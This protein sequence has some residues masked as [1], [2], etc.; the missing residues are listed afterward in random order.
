MRCWRGPTSKS[1]ANRLL[2]LATLHPAPVNISRLPPSSD[3]LTL[4]DCL[5]KIGLHITLVESPEGPETFEATVSNSFPAC[6][7]QD[8][9]PL[10]L[11]SGDGGTTNR[12]LMGLLA[13]GK[14]AYRLHPAGR[15]K[16]RPVQALLDALQS[17]GV[18]TRR[19]GDDFWLEIQGPLRPP[20]HIEVDARKSSQMASAL[21]LALA[22][23]TAQVTASTPCASPAY[24]RLTQKLVE[25]FKNGT[26]NWQVPVDWSGLSYLLALGLLEAPV[27]LA[28]AGDPDPWQADSTFLH[29]IQEMGGHPRQTPQG[30]FLSP[31]SQLS[32]IEADARQCPD[33]IPTLAVV[34]SCAGGTSK[35]TNLDILRSKESDRIEE[36]QRLLAHFGV[37]HTFATEAET[38]SIDGPTPRQIAP[39]TYWPPPDHRLVM[40]AALFM[41]LHGGGALHNAHHA[42]KSFPQ[43]GAILL[44]GPRSSSP[45]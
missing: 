1:Y 26:V 35:L 16:E 21:G 40:C 29:L 37:R 18:H 17:L 19:G 3:V 25:D 2:I 9:R 4:V 13:R 44:D 10:T 34:C 11:E 8:G 22:D 5:R 42:A 12:F 20:R 43:F 39:T 23:E 30:L 6:E 38:L 7:P 45:Y 28:N 33:L 14:K 31:P 15:M 36:L 27:L 24:W 32:P 41:R